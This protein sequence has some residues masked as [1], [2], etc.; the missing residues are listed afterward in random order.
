MTKLYNGTELADALGFCTTKV[1]AMKKMG[2]KFS[3]GRQ[4]TAAEALTWLREHPDFSITQAYPKKR[5]PKQ[6]ESPA[7]N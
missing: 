3:H 1:Q 4:T 2:F 7:L 5:K 6:V